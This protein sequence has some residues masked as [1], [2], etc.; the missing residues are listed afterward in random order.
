MGDGGWYGELGGRHPGGRGVGDCLRGRELPQVSRAS[1][2]VRGRDTAP[3]GESL[4]GALQGDPELLAGR[5]HLRGPRSSGLCVGS[6]RLEIR[7]GAGN[8][9][10]K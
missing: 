6:L 2:R 10:G 3:L 1:G 8:G 5:Q 7:E 9:V 4:E